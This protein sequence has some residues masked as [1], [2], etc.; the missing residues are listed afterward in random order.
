MTRIVAFWPFLEFVIAATGEAEMVARTAA[1]S[2][3]PTRAGGED[4]GSYTNSL[5]ST[6]P[7]QGVSIIMAFRVL[8]LA[9]CGF[10]NVKSHQK[11][12]RGL[13]VRLTSLFTLAGPAFPN[14]SWQ[15]KLTAGMPG[16]WG[17]EAHFALG[18]Q[19]ESAS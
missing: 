15:G 13:S 1:R 5:K 14:V 8:T 9:V 11:L 16:G 4:D 18:S 2:P 3:P 10:P 19:C 17:L 7:G 6:P 12:L